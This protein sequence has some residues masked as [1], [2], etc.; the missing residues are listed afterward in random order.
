MKT[1]FDDFNKHEKTQAK[2]IWYHMLPT[3]V[4]YPGWFIP[5]PDPNIFAS[6]IPTFFIPDPT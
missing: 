2:K 6:Q 5:D 3:S 4:A 1:L